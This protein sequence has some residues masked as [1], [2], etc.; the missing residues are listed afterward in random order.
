MEL[1]SQRVIWGRCGQER[2]KHGQNI[3]GLKACRSSLGS[4]AGQMTKLFALGVRWPS[5]RETCFPVVVW[6]SQVICWRQTCECL[7]FGLG[8]RY[9][10]SPRRCLMMFDRRACWTAVRHRLR[11]LA[12]FIGNGCVHVQQSQCGR[13]RR[14]RFG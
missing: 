12:F 13:G 2:N 6:T 8:G 9:G 4:G 14:R 5:A 10:W 7:T 1:A 11:Q 3:G